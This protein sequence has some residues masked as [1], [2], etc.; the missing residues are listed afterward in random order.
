MH[1]SDRNEWQRQEKIQT[2]I[3][4]R[5]SHF[6]AVATFVSRLQIYI[7]VYCIFTYVHTVS[8]EEYDNLS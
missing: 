7:R 4:R 6:L 8:V 2:G 1:W 3:F 5:A